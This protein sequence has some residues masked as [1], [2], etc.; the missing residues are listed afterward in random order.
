MAQVAERRRRQVT[1]PIVASGCVVTRDVDGSTEVLLVHRP[2]YDDWSLPKGKQDPD[3]HVTLTAVRE[4]LEE[5]GVRVRL[6]QP[7]PHREYT[8]GDAPKVV[9]Y[10]RASIVVDKG[11]VPSNE[12]DDIAWLPLEQ[13][14]KRATHPLDGKLV[15]LARQPATTPFVVLRHGH[16]VKRSAWSGEDLERPL[17]TLGVEQSDMLVERI[18][19]YGV[20][21]VHTSE[22]RR[23]VQSVTPYAEHAGL[24]VV[25][26]PALTENAYEE[27]P[28]AGNAR[29][30]GLLADSVRSGQ[31]TLLC[32][33]RPY[34]PDLL[35]HLLEGSGLTAP[36]DTVP[37]GSMIVLHPRADS[38][39]NTIAALEHHTL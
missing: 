8:V 17:D 28:A 35:D 3:E 18:A 6:Q 31:P 23:C 19:A 1:S 21:R 11:F 20:Q 24:P 10:W 27:T 16:A 14:V 37:V 5:T 33:H 36:H 32:G 30:A 2:K 15:E 39:R 12:V 34:L 29:A 13:A 26:E 7:L 25:Y 9:Y 22:A 4:V 38:A